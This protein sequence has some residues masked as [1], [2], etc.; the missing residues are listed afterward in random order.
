MRYV[1]FLAVCKRRLLAI[2]GLLLYL[3]DIATDFYVAYKYWENGDTWWFGMTVTF[4]G[5]HSIIVN[6]TSLVQHRNLW[7]CF[8]SVLQL[9]LVIRY[10]EKIYKKDNNPY[11]FAKLRHV[12]TIFESAP[13]WCLQ[14][15]V[16]LRKWH[17]PWHIVISIVLSFLSSAWSITELEIAARYEDDQ[18]VGLNLKEKVSFLVWQLFT[19]L[20]RLYAIVFFAYV[21]RYYVILVLPIH[22]LPFILMIVIV[23]RNEIFDDRNGKAVAESFLMSFSS[24]F[25]SPGSFALIDKDIRKA[26][27]ILGHIFIVIGNIVMV[28]LCLTEGIPKVSPSKSVEPETVP[29]MDVLKPIA[30]AFLSV[31][32]FVS[33]IFIVIYCKLTNRFDS[34]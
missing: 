11:S 15:Y 6:I 12:E 18:Q 24:L 16:M 4:I 3:F 33:S 17:F 5:V 29:H 19:L 20:S 31:G 8:A 7:S 30:I 27:M 25:H 32:S 23:K 2:V 28:V 1:Y 14:T 10:I 21:F 34:V 26:N 13:Q 22:W 9:S